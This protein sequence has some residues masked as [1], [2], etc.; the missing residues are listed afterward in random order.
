MKN[1]GLKKGGLKQSR[2]NYLYRKVRNAGFTIIP[3]LREID[4]YPYLEF[5][6]IPIGP[7]YYVGQLMKAGFSVQLKIR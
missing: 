6:D 7:R 3:G 4:V 1:D 2:L 5:K